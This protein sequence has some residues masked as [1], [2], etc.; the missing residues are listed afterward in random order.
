MKFKSNIIL[1]LILIMVLITTFFVNKKENIIKD[2][3]FKQIEDK[4]TPLNYK[5]E[6][7]FII[8]ELNG[9]DNSLQFNIINHYV[10]VCIEDNLIY[11]LKDIEQT[12]E[13]KLIKIPLTREN[14]NNKIKIILIPLDEKSD[15]DIDLEI[16]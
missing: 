7:T 8:K 9:N 11:E 3:T 14:I 4:N 12:K 16:K 15:N 2:L 6:Y 13:N 5:K 10:E 1:I